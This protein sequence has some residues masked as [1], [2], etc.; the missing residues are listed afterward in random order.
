MGADGEQYRDVCYLVAVRGKADIRQRLPEQTQ[1][2][3]TRP[4][5]RQGGNGIAG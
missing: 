1:F 2:M 5:F 3:S 4:H